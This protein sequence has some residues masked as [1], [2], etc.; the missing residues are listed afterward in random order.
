MSPVVKRKKERFKLPAKY[1][2]LIL[3]VLCLLLMILTFFL[4]FKISPG[5]Y[6]LG[7]T[8]VPFQ[9]GISSLGTYFTEKA[10]LIATVQELTEENKEL[11]KQLDELTIQN[12]TLQQDKFELNNLRN[13]YELDQKYSNY[14]K[15]GASIIMGSTSNWFNTFVI[16]KGSNEGLSVNMNVM[17]GSGL[18]GRIT[19]VGPNWAR[20]LSIIDDTSNVSASVL[21]TSDL[22]IVNGNLETMENGYIRFENLNDPAGNVAVGDKV[23]TSD[24]SDNFLPGI[25]VGYISSIEEDPNNLTKSGYI[26]PA[27]DFEHVSEVLVITQIKQKVE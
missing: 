15:T 7:Y 25:L 27:V 11:R 14:P 10:E 8:V 22:L 3:T 23:V 18:V 26:T 1:W 6:V 16:D 19:E 2:L 13:L 24:I 20:V 9:K 12:T 5:N 17:A 21:S 4:D